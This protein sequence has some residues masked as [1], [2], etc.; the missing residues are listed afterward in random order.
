MNVAW[1]H[2]SSAGARVDLL[3]ADRF[4]AG[5]ADCL[6]LDLVRTHLAA[7]FPEIGMTAAL[8][9]LN[10]WYIP[11]RSL[12]VVYRAS[13]NGAGTGG[14]ETVFRV[15]FHADG[16]SREQAEWA[17]AAAVEASRVRHL[18][19]LDAVASLFPEDCEVP[20]IGM[21]LDERYLQ[22]RVKAGG[23]RTLLSYLPGRR[24]AVRYRFADD[25]NGIVVRVQRVAD[26]ARS[27]SRACAAWRAASR[28]FRTPE[29]LGYDA[30]AGAMWERF[31]PGCRLD[32]LAGSGTFDRAIE[33][34]MAGLV[35]LHALQLPDLAHEG[36]NEVLKR[37]AT[38]V[39]PKIRAAFPS[40]S[41]ALDEFTSLLTARAP[42]L[43]DARPATLHGDLHT[44]NLLLDDDG[45]VFIDLDRM[46]T[47]SPAYDL[48]LLGTRLLLVALHARTDVRD[49]AATI[50]ALPERYQAAGGAPISRGTF[51][52]YVGALLVGRQ[53]KTAVRHLA[54]DVARLA[55]LLLACAR[56]TL[57]QGRFD[58][59][60]LIPGRGEVCGVCETTNEA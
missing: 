19:Q 20:Q 29:P 26:A 39:V 25:A 36:P 46:V 30:A 45:A 48:A 44:A 16:E 59:G 55:P 52:W 17:R 8:E 51:A 37:T 7:A 11:G 18:P 43:D 42:R 5:R 50:E 49:V 2:R 1:G 54:P 31:A 38:K 47:G 13:R 40:L 60:P 14:D 12:Q 3:A 53:I 34:V 33:S 9:L 41:S 15:Q 23:S 57:E 27:H 22:T 32:S 4:L 56:R 24:C 35:A 6:D 28:R 21:V 58:G 10:V